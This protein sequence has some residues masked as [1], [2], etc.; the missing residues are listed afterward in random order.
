[1]DAP[2]ETAWAQHIIRMYGK[3]SAAPRLYCWIERPPAK[4][5]AACLGDPV[6][7]ANVPHSDLTE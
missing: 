7:L 3:Q 6:D 5:M 1:M 4:P 2:G